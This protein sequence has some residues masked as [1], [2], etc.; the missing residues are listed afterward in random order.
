MWRTSKSFTDTESKPTSRYSGNNTQ[1]MIN[2]K[3]Q[4]NKR[5]SRNSNLNNTPRRQTNGPHIIVA[6]INDNQFPPMETQYK[7]KMTNKIV[8]EPIENVFENNSMIVSLDKN[9]Y[10]ISYST[11]GKKFHKSRCDSY[12]TQYKQLL[13]K[14][15][16]EMCSDAVNEILDRAFC[17]ADEYYNMYG[18][19]DIFTEEMLRY[20]Q[21]NEDYPD[22][23]DRHNM[24]DD[25]LSDD[26]LF[27]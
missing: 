13:H 18:S 4:L 16:I 26:E 10:S 22:N 20:K 21:Y 19:D 14:N 12:S 15:D 3:H 27:E 24:E 6:E 25:V 11:D 2:D 7:D 23:I 5:V 1:S 8:N 17:R 9:T